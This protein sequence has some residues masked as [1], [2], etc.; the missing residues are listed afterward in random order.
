MN[1]DA[2][3]CRSSVKEAHKVVEHLIAEEGREGITPEKIVIG[4][5]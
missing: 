3:E 2:R 5:N 1:K 4:G